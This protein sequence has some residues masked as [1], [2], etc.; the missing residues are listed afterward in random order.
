[1]PRTGLRF[2]DVARLLEVLHE[3]VSQDNSV[4]VIAHNLI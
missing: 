2:H 1:M 3:L 4:V